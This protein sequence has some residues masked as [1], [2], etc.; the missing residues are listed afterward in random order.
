[1]KHRSTA[2]LQSELLR[3]QALPKPV[4]IKSSGQEWDIT[5]YQEVLLYLGVLKYHKN[6]GYLTNWEKASEI[7]TESSYPRKQD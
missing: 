6:Q 1:M 5:P 7:I 2:V 4:C 3:S